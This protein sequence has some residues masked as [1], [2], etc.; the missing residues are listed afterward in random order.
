M[1][2]TENG[3]MNMGNIKAVWFKDSGRQHHRA[4]PYG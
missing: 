1:G 2:T 4:Q 3:L